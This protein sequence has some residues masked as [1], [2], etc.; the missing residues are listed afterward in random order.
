MTNKKI[1]IQQIKSAA[2]KKQEHRKTLVGLGLNKVHKK[3]EVVDNASTRGMI[4]AVHHLV[5]IV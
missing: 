5:K 2:G 1:T 4:N 3:V